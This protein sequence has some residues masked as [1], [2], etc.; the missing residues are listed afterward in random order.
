MWFKPDSRAR[1][2]YLIESS[3]ATS[4][5]TAFIYFGKAIPITAQQQLQILLSS[6]AKAGFFVLGEK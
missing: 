6:G 4:R 3:R 2:S 5:R 1:V